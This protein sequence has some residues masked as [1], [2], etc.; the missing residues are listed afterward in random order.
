MSKESEELAELHM[1]LMNR[2]AK[3]IGTPAA[4]Q[5]AQEADDIAKLLKACK[6]AQTLENACD[7]LRMCPAQVRRLVERAKECGYSIDID[8]NWIGSRALVE[9]RASISAAPATGVGSCFAIAS[10]LHI[11]SQHHMN[12]ALEQFVETAYKAGVRTIFVPGDL[13][14]GVYKFSIWEQ[15]ARG[16]AEQCQDAVCHLPKRDDLEWIFI[17]GNHDETFADKSGIDVGCSIVNEFVANGRNDVVYAGSR[18]ATI[19]LSLEGEPRP[20]VVEMWHP[21]GK[22]CK[23]LSH[24]AQSRID[25][26]RKNDVPDILIMGHY[27]QCS[28]FQYNGVHALQAGTF[29]GGGSS[30]GKS[31]GGEPSVGG[32]IVQYEFAVD[33]SLR[34]FAPEFLSYSEPK[35]KASVVNKCLIKC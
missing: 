20:L 8:C 28:Y 15:N 22:P 6:G 2:F 3:S 32:W 35:S 34:R 33:G 18:A 26:Y 29:Q 11:G 16:F 21:K 17:L 25:M 4:K 14:D 9:G 7:K 12:W 24:K 31:L 5:K 27:H 1:D 23:M 13:L 30:F 19:D 10:D